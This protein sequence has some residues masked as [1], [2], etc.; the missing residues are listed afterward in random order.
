MEPIQRWG[1]VLDREKRIERRDA[2]TGRRKGRRGQLIFE[3][4]S[5]TY[6]VAAVIKIVMDR[7][8]FLRQRLSPDPQG[9]RCPVLQRVKPEQGDAI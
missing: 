8:T 9:R 7:N 3:N 6:G 4:I 1:M 2:K 5:R